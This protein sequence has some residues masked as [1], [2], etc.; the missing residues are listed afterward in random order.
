MEDNNYKYTGWLKSGE[1]LIMSIP[2]NATLHEL[3]WMI[4]YIKFVKKC[5]KLDKKPLI[6]KMVNILEDGIL[7]YPK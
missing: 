3:N 5:T 7:T 1:R 6:K 2:Y 4:K